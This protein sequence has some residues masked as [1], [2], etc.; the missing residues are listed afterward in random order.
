ML[1]KRDSMALKVGF[2]SDRPRYVLN[3]QSVVHG[4]NG[5]LISQF[6]D[7]TS[8]QRT[9]KWGGSIENRARFPL[10]VLQVLIEVW[11]SDRVAIRMNPGGG[12]NDMGYGIPCKLSSSQAC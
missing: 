7:S 8:N 6:I 4:A 5:Y 12:Y 11:G 10:R 1:R 9:D 2:H 3:T